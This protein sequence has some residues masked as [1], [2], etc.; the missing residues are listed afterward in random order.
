M[1]TKAS[2]IEALS[3]LEDALRIEGFVHDVGFD[4]VSAS[5]QFIISIDLETQ[6]TY[7]YAELDAFIDGVELYQ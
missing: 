6:R 3:R 4:G 7:T 5:D 1:R 2:L